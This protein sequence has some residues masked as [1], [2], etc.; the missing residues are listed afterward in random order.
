MGQTG[1]VMDCVEAALLKL[2]TS[3]DWKVVKYVQNAL[4]SVTDAAAAQLQDT[5]GKRLDLLNE[6]EVLRDRLRLRG[7]QLEKLRQ[8]ADLYAWHPRKEA[9]Q[10]S[11]ALRAA[12]D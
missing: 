11:A 8:Q 5:N 3:P 7:I 10:A 1:L 4:P 6:A 9:S 2:S 12:E